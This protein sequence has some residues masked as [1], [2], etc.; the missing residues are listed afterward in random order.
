M[1][2]TQSAPVHYQ[3]WPPGVP[4]DID[5]PNHTLWDN[6]HNRAASD[7]DEIGME[8]VG[9]TYTWKEFEQ[10][11]LWLAGAMQ[12]LGLKTGD[13]VLLFAQNCPQFAI[14]LHAA[15]RCGAVVV[16]INPMNKAAELAFSI[17]NSGAKYAISAAEI[18]PELG[19]ANKQLDSE[20]QLEHL[21]AFSTADALPKP[22]QVPSVWRDWLCA[23]HELPA[24]PNGSVHDWS[25]LIDKKQLPD[26]LAINPDD[27]ALLMYTSGTTGNPKACMHSHRTVMANTIQPNLW[28]DMRKGDASLVVTPMFHVTGLIGCFLSAVYAGAKA[29]LMP[30]WDRRVVA[31][32]IASQNISHWTNIPTMVVDL[33]AEPEL[34]KF[35][36]SSLRYIGGGGAAMPEAVAERLKT[37]F[38]LDYIE[39]YGLTETAAPSHAN[40]SNAPR[41][42]CL[43]I[44]VINTQACILDIDTQLEA[45]ID[46]VGEILIRGPQVF[47][48]YW[49]NPKETDKAFIQLNG[50]KWFRSGDLGR[51]DANGYFYIADRLK[52]MINASGFKI[53]PA[54]VENLLH[55]HPAIHEVCVIA[56]SDPYRGQTAKAVVVLKAT[57]KGQTTADNIIAWSRDNMA[58]YKVPKEIEFVGS[59]PKGAT[60]KVMWKTLQA[61]QDESEKV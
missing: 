33:L 43:G 20:H 47:L 17:S 34:D 18:A 53:W 28:Q 54:E 35:D 10:Q 55:R 44:P 58:V 31:Q 42:Q 24:L 23:K 6:L 52:R 41:F 2:T 50:H 32:A 46:D 59:L 11:A 7:P 14:G 39:A 1:T 22:E 13:R 8:F 3:V 51:V 4:H 29:V 30:R 15:F 38:G 36:L 45:A 21:I 27:L 19:L 37:Q 48:G 40:P 57:D 9:H 16:T 26:E 61:Q 25:S 56:K 5:I 60:G 49:H 12:N